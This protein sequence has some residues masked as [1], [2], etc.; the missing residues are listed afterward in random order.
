MKLKLLLCSVILLAVGVSAF[1]TTTVT[2]TLQNLGTGTVGQGAFVRFWLRG[3][4]GNQ[5]RVNGTAVIAPSQGGVFY[6]D[7]AANSSGNV[8]G[9]LY[10]TRDVTGL[11]GGDITCGT[12]TTSV[13]YGMQVFVGG[14]GGPEIPVHALNTGTLNISSV[15]P[16]TVNP[17]IAA[18]TGDSTYLRKDA[19][20]SPVTGPLA[21]NNS[22]TVSGT[23][24]FAKINN[25]VLVD[26]NVY[27]CTDVGLN[28]AL[29]ALPSTGGTVDAR[30][31]QAGI[32][33]AATITF[34]APNKPVTLILPTSSAISFSNSSGNGFQINGSGS[35]LIGQG[36]TSSTISCTGAFT[37]D[38]I[39]VEPQS[40][41]V[42]VNNIDLHGFRVDATNC[43]TKILTNLLSVTENSFVYD[44]TWINWSAT[45]LN[46]TTSTNASAAIPEHIGI[47]DTL[48]VAK[49]GATLT[50]DSVINTGN[51]DEFGPNN[52]WTAQNATPG[53]FRG[54]V[55][56]PTA[57]TQGDG[58][59]NAF[60]Y[61]SIQGYTGASTPCISI[62]GPA[63]AS[64]GAQGNVI[65][66]GNTFE[67]CTI[68][69]Q[70]T[71]ADAAHR[72]Q[73]NS[74]FGNFFD[75]ITSNLFKC[76]FCSNNFVNEVSNGNAGD[77]L[78]TANSQGNTAIVR[79]TGSA[80]DVSDSGTANTIFTNLNSGGSNL[81]SF[82]G[83][84]AA[85]NF[86]SRSANPATSGVVQLANADIIAWKGS[87]AFNDFLF[88]NGDVLTDQI[89]GSNNVIVER[90]T[91]DALSNKTL[92]VPLTSGT[93]LQIFNTTTTCTTGASVG[94]TCTTAAIS[95]PVAEADTSYRIACTGK[96]LTNV[97]VVIAATN[98]SATQFT[99][100]IA[101]LTAAAASFASYDCI[102]GH[103]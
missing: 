27:A 98:S 57:T 24:T 37:G 77:V 6:F 99:I 62:E 40:G 58:R 55:I 93:G 20:N 3:C 44:V 92:N 15:T 28:A 96:G 71:G 87:G 52:Y 82:P 30:F 34:G 67:N 68:G 90:S 102:V 91:T 47:H 5:P 80:T 1:A 12:S 63:G 78:F 61:S 29:A 33:A 81:S 69:Y 13:W 11:L 88:R 85:A 76:D 41:Q 36:T 79:L 4:G 2:G 100:T 101:A 39:H 10:S 56:K 64:T 95:L 14:K 51:Q 21:I 70:F 43:P 7:F 83:G 72:G 22:L 49:T 94:A 60:F 86:I 26:G 103:N 50:A 18:P 65:G 38:L 89:N 46:I 84:L 32:A 59:A 9:T 35:K 31:C 74:G 75:P 45:F 48:A 97:P 19:G 42:N 16:I 17:V 25:V 23:G 8:S 66:P 53:I 54:L 73:K